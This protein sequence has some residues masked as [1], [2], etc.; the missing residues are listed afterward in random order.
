MGVDAHVVKDFLVFFSVVVHC[1]HPK[2][3]IL[4]S[5]HCLLVKYLAFGIEFAHFLVDFIK[6]IKFVPCV[7]DGV[8]QFFNLDTVFILLFFE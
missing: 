4:D 6:N 3:K 1:L 5:K 7:E 8:L 2:L